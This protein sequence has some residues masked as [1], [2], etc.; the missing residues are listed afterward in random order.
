MMLG[1]KDFTEGTDLC[2]YTKNWRKDPFVFHNYTPWY[3]LI[4]IE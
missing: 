3:V 2:L 4:L 1:F